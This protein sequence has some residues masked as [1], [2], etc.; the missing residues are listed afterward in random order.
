MA[1]EDLDPQIG[2]T[3]HARLISGDSRASA[4][5]AELFL[6]WLCQR[7]RRLC[8]EIND[9]HL[10]DSASIDAVGE[11]KPLNKESPFSV[12]M[13]PKKKMNRFSNESTSDA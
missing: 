5:I 11:R 4:E 7:M 9:R 8:P 2:R 13:K 3:L 10:L 6:P 12:R 1:D